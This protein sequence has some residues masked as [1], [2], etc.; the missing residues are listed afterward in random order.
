MKHII[1]WHRYLGIV[2]GLFV[3][4]LAITGILLN[5]T[6]ELGLSQ[7]QTSNPVLM[8]LYGIPEP[9]LAAVYRTSNHQLL[10]SNEGVVLDGQITAIK[11]PLH[12]MIEANGILLVATGPGVGLLSTE[13]ELIDII[14][15]PG[16]VE[17]IGISEG[18]I[19]VKSDQAILRMNEAMTLLEPVP[20][21][22]AENV[23]WSTA[24]KLSARELEYLSRELPRSAIPVERVVL[25]LHS[26]R[27]FGYLG[28]IVFDLVALVM[29]GLV[30]SGLWVWLWRRSK[31]ATRKLR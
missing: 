8:K 24:E 16:P 14:S 31:R 13:G 15:T 12:G 29:L 25:D 10:A 19:L 28:V 6:D 1:K 21:G 3:V 22:A 17:G 5:H 11:S 23:E 27:L 18:N 7:R 4:I 2:I 26:G 20:V 9:R 30:G